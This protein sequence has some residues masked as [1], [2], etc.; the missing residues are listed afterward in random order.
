MSP[1]QG[2][3]TI[4]LP[5]LAL[6]LFLIASWSSAGSHPPWRQSLSPVTAATDHTWYFLFPLSPF[7]FPTDVFWE[8]FLSVSRMGGSEGPSSR[9]ALCRKL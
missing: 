1:P 7:Q 8:V 6:P 9:Q 2:V 3:Q 5:G 4:S